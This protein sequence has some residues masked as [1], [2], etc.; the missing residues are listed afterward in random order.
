MGNLRFFS[1]CLSRLSTTLCCDSGSV[2]EGGR[3]IILHH[4]RCATG[5]YCLWVVMKKH[6]EDHPSHR[7]V[8]VGVRAQP[9]EG[10][11][12]EGGNVGETALLPVTHHAPLPD[13]QPRLARARWE[14]WAAL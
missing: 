8:E 5:L 10:P 2:W 7:G 1:I 13:R 3:H 9:Q 6:I 12:G 4:G 14:V 11:R